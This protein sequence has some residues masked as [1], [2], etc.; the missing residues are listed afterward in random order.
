MKA[1]L[2]IL[3]LPLLTSC[4]TAIIS[5][6]AA[7]YESKRFEEIFELPNQSKEDLYVKVNSWMVET[8]NSAESVIEFSDK[9]AGKV[10]GKY[11]F[12]FTDKIYFY[13]VKQN[14][15]IS[16]KENKVKLEIKN[17]TYRTTMDMRVGFVNSSSPLETQAG[18]DR[19]KIEWN[20]LSESL[21]AFLRKKSN[22]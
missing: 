4:A 8:F 12:V 9:E 2:L 6:P 17:P 14:I 16:V 19:A 20:T 10:L 11:T 13:Q 7:S 21:L 15:E 1:F 5:G 3:C 18:I 22:W